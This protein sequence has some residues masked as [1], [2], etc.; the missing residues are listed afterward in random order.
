MEAIP[1]LPRYSVW[2]PI[3][4][5]FLVEHETVL[6][7]IP[8]MGEEVLCKEDSF[9]EDLIKNYD[10]KIHDGATETGETVEDDVL[11]DL[12]EAMKKYTVLPKGWLLQLL[13][14]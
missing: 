11:Q 14:H 9:I 3:Q 4:E 7:H 12:V 6:H 13:F 10:G 8:Y 5:N 1:A 2:C